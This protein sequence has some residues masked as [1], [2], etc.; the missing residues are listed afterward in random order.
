MQNMTIKTGSILSFSALVILIIIGCDPGSGSNN[1]PLVPMNVTMIV[2]DGKSATNDTVLS[3]A[4][5]GDY[6]S[7][8]AISIDSTFQRDVW[9]DYDSLIFLSVPAR[10]GVVAVYGLFAAEGGGTTGLIRDIIE[11]DLHAEIIGFSVTACPETLSTGDPVTFDIITGE[12]GLAEVTF[13]NYFLDLRMWEVSPG[14]YSRMISIPGGIFDDSV[15]STANFR[16]AVGNRAEPVTYPTPLVIRGRDINPHLTGSL[17]I[18]GLESETSLVRGG[19]CFIS[20]ANAAIHLVDIAIPTTPEYIRSIPMSGWCRGMAANE[21]LLY[22]ADGDAGLAILGIFPPNT[23]DVIGRSFITGHTL[24]VELDERFVYVSTFLSG[25][26][27]LDVN[28][29]SSPEILARLQIGGYGEVAIRN[30]NVLFLAGR[31]SVASIDISDARNPVLL[32]E[33]PVD[34]DILDGVYFEDK[35]F[36]ATYTKG[37]VVIDVADPVNP[38]LLFEH[39]GFGNVASVALLP[40]YLA[41][42]RGSSISI[43]NAGAPDRLPVIGTIVGLHGAKA[44]A[45]VDNS[46]FIGGDGWFYTAEIYDE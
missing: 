5:H 29:W 35:L 12:P 20:D 7:R 13:G 19:I 10:E 21:R 36:L 38:R 26:W 31:P 16:D 25:L 3:V 8:M 41:V 39:E 22:L 15:F 4:I 42:S 40:P 17:S 34:G 14:R 28:D 1:E 24:D 33:F 6:I 44:L 11:I 46:L 9:Q 23:A 43:V 32:N 37:V 45:V 27:V 30:G 18:P 2:D